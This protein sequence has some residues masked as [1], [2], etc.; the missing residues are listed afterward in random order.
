MNLQVFDHHTIDTDLLP[1]GALVLDVGAYGWAFSSALAARGC[2][3]YA[4][5]PAPGMVNPGTKGVV[6][7][8]FGLVGIGQAGAGTLVMVRDRSGWHLEGP[9]TPRDPRCPQTAVPTTDIQILMEKEKILRWD[10]VKLNC[11]GAELEILRTWPGPI[12][13]QICV[14]FHCHVWPEHA[15]QIPGI[16]AHLGQWYD[17]VQ[18]PWDERYSAGFNYWDT[19]LCLRA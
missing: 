14:S 18:H 7:L 4:L 12:A 17:V 2:I 5:D 16:L 13:K 9:Q 11:E 1:N 8:P 15:A 19:V 3:V 6:F 10:A